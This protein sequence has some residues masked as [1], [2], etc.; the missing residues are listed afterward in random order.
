LEES[1][2]VVCRFGVIILKIHIIIFLRFYE[3]AISR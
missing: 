1:R 3:N 2:F